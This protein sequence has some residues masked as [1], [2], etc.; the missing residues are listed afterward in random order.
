MTMST[1][2]IKAEGCKQLMRSMSEIVTQ[3]SMGRF[4][5]NVSYRYLEDSLVWSVKYLMKK[6]LDDVTV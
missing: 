5:N 3:P 4:N 2:S 6:N 1:A